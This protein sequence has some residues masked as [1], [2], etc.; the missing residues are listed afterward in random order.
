MKH[1]IFSRLENVL[2]LNEEE[3]SFFSKEG[4]FSEEDARQ[5]LRRTSGAD[6]YTVY[7]L[8]GC[9]RCWGRVLMRQRCS[10]FTAPLLCL[11]GISLRL[12]SQASLKEVCRVSST[13]TKRDGFLLFL[14]KPPWEVLFGVEGPFCL[15]P[16]TSR[17]LCVISR[18]HSS[19]DSFSSFDFCGHPASCWCQPILRRQTLGLRE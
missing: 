17:E 14:R 16:V 6:I 19:F 9:G 4:C 18:R 8:G 11:E 12:Q 15:M 3:R 10:P 13:T 1:L 7:S 5:L 2:F